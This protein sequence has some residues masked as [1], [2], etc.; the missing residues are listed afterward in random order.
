MERVSTQP[1]PL[2]DNSHLVSITD[3]CVAAR[4]QPLRKLVP[5]RFSPHLRSFRLTIVALGYSAC[6]PS[7]LSGSPR[8]VVKM[9]LASRFA[10]AATVAFIFTTMTA[11]AASGPC[12]AA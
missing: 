4:Q 10:A 12:G 6:W 9:H 2:P 7:A 11:E 8:K 5:R 3:L 1:G